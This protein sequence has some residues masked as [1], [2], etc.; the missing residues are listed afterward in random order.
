MGSVKPNTGHAEA[1]AV[2][3]S[4]A[5]VLIAM[6]SGIIPANLYYNKPNP[7]IAG[8]VDGRL[9][10]VTENTKWQGGLMAINGIGLA[11]SYGHIL[12]RPNY[13]IKNSV[14]DKLPRLINISTRTEQGIQ[15]ILTTVSKI[16]LA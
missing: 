4:L 6:D 9:R 1:S 3:I 7:N 12:L 10:V 15:D 16:V 14:N 13:K 2:L 11:S 8:L 5:K